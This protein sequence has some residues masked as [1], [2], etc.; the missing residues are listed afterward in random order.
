MKAGT[1]RSLTRSAWANT[2]LSTARQL[3]VTA[4]SHLT[5]GP[6]ESA[7]GLGPFSGTSDARAG[8]PSHLRR[9]CLCGHHSSCHLS[10]RPREDTS[11]TC[12][13]V[14]ATA[15]AAGAAGAGAAATA[16]TATAAAAARDEPM[17][18]C[19]YLIRHGLRPRSRL[20]WDLRVPEEDPAA[21]RR[22]PH[23]L[24]S[25][26]RSRAPAAAST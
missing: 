9:R 8:R 14:A 7:F 25:P 11:T 20:V 16:A 1:F 12:R 6:I 15:R 3:L 13:Q 22:R 26:F 23:L 17:A 24:T 4:S 10:H 2:I 18:R 5:S 19:G 21:G